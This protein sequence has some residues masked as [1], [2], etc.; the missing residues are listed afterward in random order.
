MESH[1]CT[2]ITSDEFVAALS[3]VA[4]ADLAAQGVHE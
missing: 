4:P 2:S 3:A 1:I